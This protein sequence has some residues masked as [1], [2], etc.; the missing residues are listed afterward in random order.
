MS[1]R[2][3]KFL[4]LLGKNLDDLNENE[5]KEI[6]R[7]ILDDG[8]HGIC[9]SL[10]EDGQEPGNDISDEQIIRRLEI[11]K[12]HTKWIRIFSS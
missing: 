4:S 1:Y 3:E 7:N 9:F 12:P 10:Y 6:S 5:L 2:S 8:L 11:L